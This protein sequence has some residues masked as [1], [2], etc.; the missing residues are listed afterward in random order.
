VNGDESKEQ[1]TRLEVQGTR[2]KAQGARNEVQGARCKERGTR[3]KVQG[4]RCKDKNSY[5]PWS[6]PLKKGDAGGLKNDVM[7]VPL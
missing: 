2:S 1:G 7:D 4:T 3:N 6:P 5:E